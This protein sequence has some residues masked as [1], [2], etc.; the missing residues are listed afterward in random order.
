MAISESKLHNL[1]G[2]V[3]FEGNIPKGK[4]LQLPKACSKQHKGQVFSN[5]V[6]VKNGKLKNVL[7]RITK[8]LEGKKYDSSIP[9]TAVEVDQKGV[10]TFQE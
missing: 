2:V 7:V 9:E 8:G 1:K 3:T 4:K 10:S 6:I 5:E